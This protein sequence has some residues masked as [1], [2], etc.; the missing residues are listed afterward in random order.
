[1]HPRDEGSY[2]DLTAT[3]GQP[4]NM[5]RALSM[6]PMLTTTSIPVNGGTGTDES[7]IFA[8]DFRRLIIG[9]R[10]DIRVEVIKSAS[11]VTNLQYDLVA[12]MRAD[13]AVTHANAFFTLTGVG[14]AA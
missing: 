7:T 2:T 10:S 13:I 3:D 4:L 12:H 8:G 11:Y 14:R 6:I 9:I 5:P 1:M